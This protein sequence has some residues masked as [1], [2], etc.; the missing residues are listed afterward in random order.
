MKFYVLDDDESI[1]VAVQSILEEHGHE[2][3]GSSDPKGSVDEVQNGDYDFVLLDYRMPD[4]NGAWFLQ[5]VELPKATKVLLM[6]G[7]V[8]RDV[9]ARMFELGASGYLIKPFSEEDLLHHI[10]FFSR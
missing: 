6:T 10:E 9:I 3:V 8:D 1:L 7:Y 4:A 2:V 5:Q